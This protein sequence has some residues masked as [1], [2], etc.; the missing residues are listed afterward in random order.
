MIRKLAVAMAAPFV[1]S[2][3]PP[4]VYTSN[5]LIAQVM[6]VEGR[7]TAFK[8]GTSRWLSVNH[9]TRMTG[10]TIRGKPATVVLKSEELDFSYF[11]IPDDWHVGMKVSC[12]GFKA[13]ESYSAIGYA[14]GEPRQLVIAL[15]YTGYKHVLGQSILRG[16]GTVIPGMSGGP[17]LNQRGEVV[18]TVNAF[19][20]LYGLSFS[21]ALRDTAICGK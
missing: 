18:G 11:Q 10:C 15:R 7:G 16:W 1:A 4:P 17:V 13:G 21:T 3:A 2:A 9:V 8:V 5:P 19:N 6:C 14:R 12:E 20:W